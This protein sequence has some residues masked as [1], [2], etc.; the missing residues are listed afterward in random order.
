MTNALITVDCSGVF[1]LISLLSVIFFA[2]LLYSLF[3]M[4]RNEKFSA[5]HSFPQN[6]LNSIAG[7]FPIGRSFDFFISHFFYQ[8]TGRLTYAGAYRMPVYKSWPALINAS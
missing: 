1:C 8:I 6:N 5:N 3:I 2:E 7:L 4:G